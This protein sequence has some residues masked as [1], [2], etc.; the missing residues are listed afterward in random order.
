MCLVLE[1]ECLRIYI[2]I[3]YESTKVSF[4][5]EQAQLM[6]NNLYQS[7]KDGILVEISIEEILVP[8][9]IVIKLRQKVNTMVNKRKSLDLLTR[10]STLFS[11]REKAPSPIGGGLGWS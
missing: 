10:F 5:T 9:G 6:W 7:C 2:N 1:T 11:P 3:E 4:I 8:V